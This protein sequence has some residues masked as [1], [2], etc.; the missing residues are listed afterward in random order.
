[1]TAD[2]GLNGT[3]TLVIRR[4]TLMYMMIN[5][6]ALDHLDIHD[7][8]SDLDVH[9]EHAEDDLDV[10]D[11]KCDLDVHDEDKLD[12]IDKGKPRCHKQPHPHSAL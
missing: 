10:H 9:Y 4:M 5:D 2:I 1:M 7:G 3:M 8:K 12:D 11:P 6:H